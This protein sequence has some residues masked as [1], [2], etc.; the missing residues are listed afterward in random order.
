MSFINKI[1]LFS[2]LIVSTN[3]L[4]KGDLAIRAKKLELKLGSEKSDY[5]MSQKIFEMET[6][7]AYRLEISS[8]G[9]KEYEIEAEDFFR[10][11]WVRGIEVEGIEIDTPVIN[12]IELEREGE[13]EIKFVPIRPGDYEFEI[14]G[15]QSKG[16]KGLFKVR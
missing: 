14:E 4:G 3:V 8:M 10:N 15:L 9:F 11:I 2:I 1:L 6:G 12:E 5:E 7:K 13:I 16:M